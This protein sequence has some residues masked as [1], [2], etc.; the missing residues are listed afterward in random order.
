MIPLVTIIGRTTTEVASY[1]T[2]SAGLRGRF[3]LKFGTTWEDEI[4]CEVIQSS[5][6]EYLKRECELGSVVVATGDLVSYTL[7]REDKKKTFHKLFNCQVRIADSCIGESINPQVI[8]DGIALSEPQP[9]KNG[10]GCYFSVGYSTY[11]YTLKKTEYHSIFCTTVET[12]SFLKMDKI[13]VAGVLGSTRD[14]VA[15][16]RCNV[17][18]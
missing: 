15:L 17:I 2:K 10:E 7:E 8:I 5:S 11:N 16:F 18:F 12:T 3:T 1:P 6:V 14:T 13:T 9:C 4:A